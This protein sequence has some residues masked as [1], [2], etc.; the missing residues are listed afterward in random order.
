P[1]HDPSAAHGA[2]VA[3]RLQPGPGYRVPP[4]GHLGHHPVRPHRLALRPSF[5]RHALPALAAHAAHSRGPR[6]HG[7]RHGHRAGAPAPRRAR[8]PRG[9]R[10]SAPLAGGAV[11]E[12]LFG[13]L[14]IALLFLLFALG[15]EIS[16]SLGLAGVIG[17]LYLKGWKVG[18]GVVGSI[19]WT[20]AT[21]FSFI[22][23]PLFVFM[24]GIL[25]TKR[26]TARASSP[27]WRAG[28]A[29]FRAGW[30]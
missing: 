12:A 22:A 29:F 13:T 19:A 1:R 11:S 26:G 7:G 14:L 28:W 5:R 4:G 16:I 27:R 21:S 23:V 18:M 10:R 25:Q 24:S 2:R 9:P 17:L 30:P 6:P 20:N 8:A 15:L 3:A